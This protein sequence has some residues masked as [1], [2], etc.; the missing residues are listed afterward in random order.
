MAITDLFSS[1]FLFSVAIIIILIGGIFA[2]ISYRMAEQDHKLNAMLG[3]VT[4]M[5]GETQFFRSKIGLIQQQLDQTNDL[6]QETH[7]IHLS[8][9]DLGLNGGD[10]HKNLINVSDD[11]EEDEEE[12][13]DE[14]DEDEEEDDEED[15]DEEEEEEEDEEF[16]P[17]TIKVITLSDESIPNSQIEILEDHSIIQVEPQEDDNIALISNNLI[18]ELTA[19]NKILSNIS[20]NDLGDSED[21]QSSK[22]EYKKL[23]LNKLR[24]VV[25]NKRLTND[26]SKLKKN[27]ILKLLGEE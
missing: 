11:E 9:G 14:E 2:F 7:H 3:L 12:D 27:E 6:S 10:R 20:I 15:D 25:V 16:H 1:S 24:E 18:E 26:A 4:T 22:N 5:A 17:E 23:S 19:D 8:P 13:E 21:L